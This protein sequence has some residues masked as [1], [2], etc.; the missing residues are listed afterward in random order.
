MN[1]SKFSERLTELMFDE[2]YNGLTLSQ[3]LGCGYN[4]VYRYLQCQR[5]PEVEMLV[6]LADFFNCSIDYLLGLTDS[7][8]INKFE[9]CPPFKDRFAQ[10]LQELNMTQYRLEKITGIS[11]S[12]VGY[13][14]NGKKKPTIDNIIKIAT[15]LDISIDF[16]LGR[17]KD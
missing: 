5:V 14:K 11:H 9:K 4:T 16:V 1:M 12:T 2:G 8:L 7:N 3:K 6:V 17:T 13:W 15:S 10:L